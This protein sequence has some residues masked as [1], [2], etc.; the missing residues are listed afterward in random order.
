MVEV[1]RAR[2]IKGMQDGT[3][4]LGAPILEAFE[5]S[6]DVMRDDTSDD[7]EDEN[8]DDYIITDD[9]YLK[10]QESEEEDEKKGKL[11]LIIVGVVAGIFVAS[12]VVIYLI[13]KK[14]MGGS[15]AQ[16]KQSME[17]IKAINHDESL[18][19]Q[20]HPKAEIA[21]IYDDP[22]KMR[23]KI[24]KADD[25]SISGSPEYTMTDEKQME[26]KSPMRNSS[27]PAFIDVEENEPQYS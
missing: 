3:I 9:E 10:I 8:D 1:I 21:N 18:E 7:D 23:A 6:I 14:K 4:N 5:D 15:K 19:E 22:D 2:Y 26:D 25:V 17:S 20:Y 11:V 24:N 12:L 27:R 16:I 13:C